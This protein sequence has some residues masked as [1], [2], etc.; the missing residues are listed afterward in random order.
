MARPPVPSGGALPVAVGYRE[1][2]GRID[3]D[4][5]EA[6][7]VRWVSVRPSRRSP[8]RSKIGFSPDN[9]DTEKVQ[10]R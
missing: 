2:A 7:G 6:V 1:G 5:S 3:T 8:R 4:A 10:Y 9:I